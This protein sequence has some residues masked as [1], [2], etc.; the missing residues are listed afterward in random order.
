MA[1]ETITIP[2]AEYLR[3]KKCEEVDQELL[4]Q[5]VSSLEDV[6]AG[7]LRRVC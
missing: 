7:R 1:S 5:I 2:K 3:L 6:K 4:S